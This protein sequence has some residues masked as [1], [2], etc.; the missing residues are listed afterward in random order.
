MKKGFSL[1]EMLIYIAVFSIVSVFLIAIL[2]TFTRIEVRQTAVNDV[3]GQ[4]SFVSN[5]VQQLVQ[6]SSLVNMTD[7]VTTSTLNLRTASSSQDPTL[8]YA[9]G[10]ALYLEQGSAASVALTNANVNVTNFSVTPYENPGGATVVQM[11]LS[12]TYNNPNPA[13]QFAQSMQIAVAKTSAATFD[14]S[15]Y[16]ASST[17]LNFGSAVNPWGNGYFSGNLNVSGEVFSGTGVSGA[18][19]LKANGNVGFSNSSQG[20]ILMAPGGTCFLVSVN[21]SGTLSTV[22]AACP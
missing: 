15:L 19:A 9:S 5:V 7:G 3:N 12:L 2:T 16:P 14:S 17:S 4:I 10:T 21:A 22:T 6:N 13:S 8:V 18:T 1:I 11:N 20:L